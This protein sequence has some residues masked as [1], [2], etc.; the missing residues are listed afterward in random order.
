MS[1]AYTVKEIAELREVVSDKLVFGSYRGVGVGSYSE[2][3]H[4]TKVEEIVRTHM[5][6]GHTANDL[7]D[8]EPVDDWKELA[9]A[10]GHDVVKYIAR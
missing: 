9:E 8:S 10:Y 3:E 1:R 6:A 7:R 4:T 2:P 5:M